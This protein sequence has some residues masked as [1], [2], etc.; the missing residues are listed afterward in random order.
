M[1]ADKTTGNLD[2]LRNVLWPTRYTEPVDFSFNIL[3]EYNKGLFTFNNF[4]DNIK[5]INNILISCN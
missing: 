3:S 1:H 2:K 5:T 4:N